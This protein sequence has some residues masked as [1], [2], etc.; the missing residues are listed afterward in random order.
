MRHFYY[1]HESQARVGV[2]FGASL[3]LSQVLTLTLRVLADLLGLSIAFPA[4]ILQ[5]GTLLIPGLTSLARRITLSRGKLLYQTNQPA[6]DIMLL[7]EGYGR[8][9]M[10]E[11]A[12]S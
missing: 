3:A 5:A 9:C 2:R 1:Q 4:A 8:L 12:D 11:E 7:T 6:N 10:A